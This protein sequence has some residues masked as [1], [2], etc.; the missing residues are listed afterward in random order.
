MGDSPGSSRLFQRFLRA[1]FDP[2]TVAQLRDRSFDIQSLAHL[3]AQEKRLAE[4]VLLQHLEQGSADPRIVVGLRELGSQQ[5]VPALAQRVRSSRGEQ[6]VLAP[7]LALWQLARSPE[8]VAALIEALASLPDFLG[9]V[10]AAICLRSCRCQ[11]AAQALEQALRDEAPLV[12]YHAA[13]SL[14]IIYAPWRRQRGSHPL[15][16]QMMS[17]DPEQQD[18]ARTRILTLIKKRPL[19]WDEEREEGGEQ[20]RS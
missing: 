20:H 15:A 18:T 13:T 2:L 7:A 19:P 11:P 1:F 16:R 6:G 8:A 17:H 10:D 3:S 9:R 5:A 12:R 14:L 4:E